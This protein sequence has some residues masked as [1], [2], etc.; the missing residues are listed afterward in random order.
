MLQPLEG[1]EPAPRAWCGRSWEGL[2]DRRYEAF[3]QAQALMQ[4]SERD[5][6]NVLSEFL[7]FFDK[8][9]MALMRDEEEWIFSSFRPA[10][11][12]VI[13]ALE[14]HIAVTSLV[15]TL[16]KDAEAGAVDLELLHGLGEILEAHLLGEEEE[17]RPLVTRRA[18]L[19]VAR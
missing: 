19:I 8:T 14:E 15:H 16:V 1:T 11:D 7:E 10:P 17:V 13:R 5:A 9:G 2:I 3:V 6:H 4:A 12:A 18:R